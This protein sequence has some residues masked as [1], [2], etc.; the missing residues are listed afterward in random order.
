MKR[1]VL[2]AL[3]ALAGGAVTAQQADDARPPDT[4]AEAPGVSY[5]SAFEDYRPFRDQ[6]LAPWREVNDEVAR[7]GGHLGIL[8][9]VQKP[10]DG[11]PAPA[12][13]HSHQGMHR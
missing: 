7:V 2:F 4:R 6:E 5:R 12:G 13:G 1:A 11:K 9:S 8:K 10:Q 3:S